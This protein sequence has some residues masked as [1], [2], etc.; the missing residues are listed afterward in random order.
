M[1]ERF[2]KLQ[3]FCRFSSER[4]AP[5]SGY[6]VETIRRFF[7]GDAA[8]EERIAITILFAMKRIL[9][10]AEEQIESLEKEM[11]NGK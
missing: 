9:K 10:E 5:Y 8:E 3:T 6:N 7:K 2:Q 11:M 4:I 1:L